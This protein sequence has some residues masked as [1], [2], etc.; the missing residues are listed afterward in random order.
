MLRDLYPKA[1]LPTTCPDGSN[2]QL[3]MHLKNDKIMAELGLEFVP[4][5][6]TLKAQCEALGRAGLLKL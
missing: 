1:P 5:Q 2:T 3:C 4:L 6:Q